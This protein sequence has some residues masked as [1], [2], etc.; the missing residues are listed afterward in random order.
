M[1]KNF[2][3]FIYSQGIVTLFGSLLSFAIDLW[4]YEITK[5]YKIFIFIAFI[6]AIVPLVFSLITGILSDKFRKTNIL[7]LCNIIFILNLSFLYYLFVNEVKNIHLYI[8]FIVITAI[9][10]E[11]RYTASSSLIPIISKDRIVE[12]NSI[13]QFFRGAIVISSPTLAL[14]AYNFFGIKYLIILLSIAQFILLV[15]TFYI[16]DLEK[17]EY[18]NKENNKNLKESFQWIMKNKSLKYN[19]YFF[20]MIS[21]F[22]MSYSAIIIPYIIAKEGANTLA[23]LITAQGCGMLL[24][25]ILI[26]KIKIST[27]SIFY[28]STLIVGGMIYLIGFSNIKSIIYFS[29]FGIGFFLGLI[30][31]SNQSIWQ[32]NIPSEM[33]GKI[34]SIRS[35]ILYTISPIIIFSI[36]PLSDL[37]KKIS[38]NTFGFLLTQSELLSYTLMV[39]GLF[40]V[41]G[42]ILFKRK[43]LV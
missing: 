9:V 3:Y 20:S 27:N 30:S 34:I 8:V 40:I 12:Y 18:K 14:I 38:F 19:L 22:L 26:K 43:I 16:K 39:I 24:S 13:Q 11:F 17:N 31:I 25:S 5:S 29:G 1:E 35:T 37:F 15:S 23:I 33:Q 41:T 21:A 28:Y 4:I 2:K 36:I 10:N 7:L 6:M 32:T 42:S